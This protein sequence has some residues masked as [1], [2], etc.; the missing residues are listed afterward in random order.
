[1]KKVAV[2]PGGAGSSLDPAGALRKVEIMLQIVNEIKKAADDAKKSGKT[3]IDVAAIDAIL[4]PERMIFD[5]ISLVIADEKNNPNSQIC[6]ISWVSSV[7]SSFTD[8]HLLMGNE[9]LE[10]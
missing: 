5:D 10:T 8:T 3:T 4:T 6:C 7:A 1:M 2:S 9:K